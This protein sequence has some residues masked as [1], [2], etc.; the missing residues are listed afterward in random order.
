[1]KAKIPFDKKYFKISVYLFCVIALAIV[2][3]KFLSNMPG[4]FNAIGVAWNA[5]QHLLFPF[6]FGFFIAYVINPFVRVIERNK[7]LQKLHS[8]ARR[9][10]SILIAYIIFFG[11]I[12]LIITYLVPEIVSAAIRF[13]ASMPANA[14]SLETAIES[15]FSRISFIEGESVAKSFTEFIEPLINVSERAPEII[16]TVVNSTVIAAS[17]ILNAILG[18]FIAFYM[19]QDKERFAAYSKKTVYAILDE[20]TA[21]HLIKNIGRIDKIFQGFIVG[22]FIDSLIIGIICF[23]GTLLLKMPYAPLISVI[24]GVTNMIPYFGPFIGA[25]PSIFIVLLSD[26]IKAIVIAIFILILQQFDGNILGPKILG[27]STGVNPLWIILSILIGGALAGPVGMF[28]GVP[29][30]ASI[31]MFVVDFIDRRYAK[32]YSY[33]EQ[34]AHEDT[35]I[36]KNIKE[37]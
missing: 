31:K 20:K 8:R 9:N 10:L 6:I 32:K 35:T 26:P 12:A 30:F 34:I 29:V 37:D 13:F 36:P 7:L 21:T 16:E 5:F 27:S 33:K 25:I 11:L 14:A 2:L 19:L 4:I 1:M 18:I 28:L 15:F 17:T 22:K 23:A 3:E 24:V